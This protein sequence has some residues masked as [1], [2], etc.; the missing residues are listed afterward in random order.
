MARKSKESLFPLH[1]YVI[2]PLQLG[3]IEL[4]RHL[5]GP[6]AGTRSAWVNTGSGLQYKVL[7]DRGLDIGEAF[8][9]GTSLT[10][11]SLGGSPAPEMALNK[12][13]DWLWGFYCGLLAS[14]GPSS[15]GAP[16]LDKGQ[17]LSLH[18]RHSNIPATIESVVSPDPV[19]GVD[20][21]S[22]TGIVREAKLFNPNQELRRTISS[23]L[24]G[25]RIIIEDTIINRGNE[26]AD[27]AW[28]LH[29]NFGY[30]LLEP[31][32]R[33]IFS[34][35]VNPLPAYR[36]YYTK[37]NFTVIP[38]PLNAHR[39]AGEACAYIDP[40]ADRDGLVHCGVLNAK[41]KIAVKISFAKAHFP[42]FVNWQHF[43]PDGQ[44][45]MGIE[46]ANCGVEGRNVDRQR[47]WLDRLK[48]GQVKQYRA[49]IEVLEG[50]KALAQF[51][52]LAG[53]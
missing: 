8:Y 14:C 44:F 24:G 6:G 43:G 34:G 50:T 2:N 27:H 28:L 23:P 45:V 38:K 9:K 7:I 36:D 48:P 15:A 17:E 19:R 11:L 20:A 46:P 18:G 1:P 49:E 22:I 21:M 40:K 13:L 39:G 4:V 30:P 26:T 33:F 29:I 16:C 52:K 31:G 35:T 12:G 53:K 37:R 25:S 5:D 47:G 41:R 10:W 32:A 51:R 3:G 42:R